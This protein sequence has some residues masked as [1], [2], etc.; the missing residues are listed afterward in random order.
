MLLISTAF[1]HGHSIDE[2]VVSSLTFL[3]E[4]SA[5]N[6][7]LRANFVRALSA[8]VEISVP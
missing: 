8:T 1:N 4:V 2:S 7:G 3:E 5:A 6:A